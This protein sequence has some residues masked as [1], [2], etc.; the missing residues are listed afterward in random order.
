MNYLD[1]LH[2]AVEEANGCPATHE[3]TTPIREEDAGRVI[4]DGE[5]ETFAL[6]GHATAAHCYAWGYPENGMLHVTSILEI[7]P[8]DS[9]EM[10]VKAAIV[11]RVRRDNPQH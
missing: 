9:P 2:R 6:S 8:V 1:Q 4:F 11:S 7:P 10:A 5:V 3:K